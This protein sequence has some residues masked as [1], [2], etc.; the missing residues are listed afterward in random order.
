MPY[1]LQTARLRRRLRRRGPV[2]D[3]NVAPFVD[4]LLV[5]VVIFMVAAPLLTV[6][7]PVDLPKTEASTIDQNDEPLV[8]SIDK[9]GR[10]FLQEAEIATDQLVPRLV[11]VS[12]ANRELRIFVRGDRELTYGRIMQV[13]GMISAAGYARVALLGELPVPKKTR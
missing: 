11:A 12:N 3:I 6:G 7:V 9:Q 2:A 5:L 1:E 8:V 10:I 13:M 4:V